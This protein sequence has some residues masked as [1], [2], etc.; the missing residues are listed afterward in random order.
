MA[1]TQ[2]QE[3]Q[4]LPDKRNR[5]SKGNVQVQKNSETNINKSTFSKPHVFL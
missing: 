4:T 1:S 5:P 2:K 3:P